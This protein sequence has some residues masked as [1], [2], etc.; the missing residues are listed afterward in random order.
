ML[1]TINFES[2]NCK[3]SSKCGNSV[4]ILVI[5]L[6]FIQVKYSSSNPSEITTK[7]SSYIPHIR[8]K[9]GVLG[10]AGMISCVTNCDPLSYKSYGCYCGIG[11]AGV[12][13]DGIDR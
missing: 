1:I 7:N 2:K 8:S 3:N 4:I 12:P 5:I 6:C 9:R 11:G 13:V 10:L